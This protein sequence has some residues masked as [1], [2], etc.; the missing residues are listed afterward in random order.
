MVPLIQELRYSGK[1]DMLFVIHTDQIHPPWRTFATII[2]MCIFKKSTCLDRLGSSRAQILWGMFN[3]KDVDYVALLWEDVTFQADNREI[4]YYAAL[5][6]EEMINQD[7]KDS[8][9]YKTYIAFVTRQDNP[10][11]ARR[12]S[13]DVSVSKKKAP[14]K[15]DRGICIDMQSGVALLEAIQL[16]KALN[17]SNEKTDFDKDKNPNINQKNDEEEYVRTPDNYE[18][19][20]DDEEYKELYKDVNVKL[21][22]VEH[23]K[24]KGDAE[25]T[26]AGRGDGS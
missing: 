15:V 22:D 24:R 19:S 26:N 11:K 21:K 3:Q 17:K 9:A 6:L 14:A 13:S 16:K 2:N 8:K 20:N 1:C 12:D 4:S 5:I 7:I 23:K 10:K 18:F 25:M